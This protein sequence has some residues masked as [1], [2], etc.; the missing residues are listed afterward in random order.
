VSDLPSYLSPVDQGVHLRVK[1]VPGASR[2]NIA[3]PL[4][5]RLKIRIAAPPEDG[6]ANNAII[7][8]LARHLGIHKNKISLV[9]GHKN[10]EKVFLLTD[11]TAAQLAD[12][13]K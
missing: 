6:K 7:A 9:S 5:D 8:L 10:P 2:Q 4:G 11:I 3:G 12:A 13:L 1:A